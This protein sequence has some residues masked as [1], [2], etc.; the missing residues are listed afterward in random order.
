MIPMSDINAIFEE[1]AATSGKNDKLAILA[2]NKDNDLFKE[3]CRLALDPFTLFYIKKIP[4]YHTPVMS[5]YLGLQL[6]LKELGRLSRREVTGNAAIDFLKNILQTVSPSDAKV[7]ERIILKDLRCG[8]D[9]AVNKVW[10]N[11]VPEFAY[12]RCSLPKEVNLDTWNWSGGIYAQLKADGMFLNINYVGNEVTFLSRQGTPLPM[13]AFSDLAADVAASLAPNTQ[14]HGEL[15]V[16]ID[17]VIAT[18]EIGNGILNK[19][20]KGKYT[21][22]ANE[23]PVLMVWDQI[24]QSAVVPG[25]KHRVAYSTRFDSLVDQV[26][27]AKHIKMI[28]NRI[29]T[30][31]DAAMDYYAECLAKGLEGAVVK[32]PEAIWE[33]TTSRGQVKLKL[34]VPVELKIVGFTVGKGKNA[35]TFGAIECE[36][37][38][39]K[40][41]VDVSGFKDKPAPGI[42]TRTQINAM[43]DQ[44]VGTVMTVKSN[45]MLPPTKNN[46]NWSLFLPVFLEFRADKKVADTLEQIQTQF[47]NAINPKK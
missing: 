20:A 35:A 29:V 42:L 26:K 3:V 43:R 32:Q 19:V 5:G 9:T 17:G 16:E 27:N 36:S 6:A 8:V 1:L 22:A 46:P 44:L 30:S 10:K 7:I 14:T 24:P 2:R 23:K 18:R 31:R 15:L 47:E 4:T 34:S 40:L 21:F 41:K 39:G 12:M 28:E 33:D 11:L 13:E 45:N 38:C 37:S 25:G